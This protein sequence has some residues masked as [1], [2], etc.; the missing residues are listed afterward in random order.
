MTA[1]SAW[2]LSTARL[3]LS[4]V[5]YSDLAELVALKGEPRAFGQM[6]GGVRNPLQTAQDLAQEIQAWGAFGYGIWSVRRL[7]GEFI[8]ITGL[9]HRPDGRGVG[10]RFAFWPEARGVGLAREAAGRALQYA[11]ECARLNRVVAV[12]AEDNFASRMVLG[13]IGMVEVERFVR[14][15]AVRL[16]YQS[17]R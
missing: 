8:G 16:V 15:G 7:R 5:A 10:L 4:P 11:H 3:R 9:T 13:S 6:L 2:C 17:I 1:L 14:D 12:A